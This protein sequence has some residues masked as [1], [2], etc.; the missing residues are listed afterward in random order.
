MPKDHS[1][2]LGELK[3]KLH[4][5]SEPPTYKQIL[6]YNDEGSSEDQYLLRFLLESNLK[7]DAAAKLLVKDIEWREKTN[8]NAI[9]RMSEREA[10]GG[11]D[12][13]ELFS[14]YQSFLYG[15]DK[16]DRPVVYVHCA[17]QNFS[18]V[19]KLVGFDGFLKFHAV[20]L[21]YFVVS[22][23]FRPFCFVFV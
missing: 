17:S 4:Q 2:A 22:A 3:Q 12:P 16:L 23:G 11:A 8:I 20:S 19:I 21:S 13:A 18:K 15:Y 10:L 1:A 7:V 6:Q 5:R 14:A 9:Q